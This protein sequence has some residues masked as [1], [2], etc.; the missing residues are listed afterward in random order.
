MNALIQNPHL[1][2]KYLIYLIAVW[3][4]IVTVLGGKKYFASS[5]IILAFTVLN[6]L[7]I[8]NIILNDVNYVN[9]YIERKEFLIVMNGGA[10][11]ILT[12]FLKLDKVAWKHVLLLCFATLC[13]IMIILNIKAHHAGFFYNWYDELII[14][15]GLLQMMVSHDGLIGAF[16]NLQ[17]LLLRTHH[18]FNRAYQ[19]LFTHKISEKS[20]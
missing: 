16:S 9:E 15:V 14:A 18:Y 7:W 19:G 12:M 3:F 8:N 11:L 17:E 4:F 10:A 2:V 1:V 20:K 13:H 6:I 5:F